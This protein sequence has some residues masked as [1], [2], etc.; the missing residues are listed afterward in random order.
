LPP[1]ELF[2]ITLIARNWDDAQARFFADNGIFDVIYKP[3]AR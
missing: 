2:P 3:K 1:L